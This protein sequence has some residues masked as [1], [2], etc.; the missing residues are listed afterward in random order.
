MRWP[1][2]GL[3]LLAA[4]ALI[5]PNRAF[6]TDPGDD[7]DGGSAGQTATG[8]GFDAGASDS[9][10]PI[11]CNGALCATDTGAT[12]CSIAG[13]VGINRAAPP[14]S[15][16]VLLALASLAALRRRARRAREPAR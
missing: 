10:G 12:A 4:L 15:A 9:Q 11:G 5:A 8:G 3:L 16:P 14:I 6:A 13:A 7:G 2:T 1:T